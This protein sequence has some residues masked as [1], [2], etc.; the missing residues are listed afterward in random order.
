MH[1]AR[2]SSVGYTL[3]ITNTADI[4]YG[5]PE[6]DR[7]FVGVLFVD[8]SFGISDTQPTFPLYCSVGLSIAPH[9]T[10]RT[11]GVLTIPLHQDDRF[12][13]YTDSPPGPATV[14]VNSWGHGVEPVDI[15]PGTPIMIDPAP[16]APKTTVAS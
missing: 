14:S 10:F 12:T 6:G 2:G 13:I 3:T 11:R 15:A 4:P 8:D 9:T 1:V 7:A 5:I 16:A